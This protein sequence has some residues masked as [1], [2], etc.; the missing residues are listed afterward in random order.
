ML[1]IMMGAPYR[2]KVFVVYVL[3]AAI[4]LAVAISGGAFE[5]DNRQ[6]LKQARENSPAV[7]PHAID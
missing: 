7:S 4:G 5:T 2:A 3:L 1:G 6:A